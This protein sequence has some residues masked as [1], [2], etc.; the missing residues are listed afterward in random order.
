MD[1]LEKLKGIIKE[2]IYNEIIEELE[3]K[4]ELEEGLSKLKTVL[5]GVFDRVGEIKK[6]TKII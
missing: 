3:E 2:D 5:D 1:A 4:E 6:T